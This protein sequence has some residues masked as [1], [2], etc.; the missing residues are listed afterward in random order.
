MGAVAPA[1]P[2]DPTKTLKYLLFALSLDKNMGQVTETVFAAARRLGIDTSS[3][4]DLVD[5]RAYIN[6]HWSDLD[7]AELYGPN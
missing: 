5:L 3:M 1:R 7:S 6:Q 2:I 4:A